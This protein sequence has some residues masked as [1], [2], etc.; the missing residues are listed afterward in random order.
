MSPLVLVLAALLAP[1]ARARISV[2]MTASSAGAS[3]VDVA[4][5]DVAVVQDGDRAA[6]RLADAQLKDA[7][8]AYHGATPTD[9]YLTSPTPWG[10]LYKKYGWSE[11]RR[12]LVPVSARVLDVSST[13]TVVARRE[14]LNTGPV[15]ATF[16]AGISETVETTYE[17]SWSTSS[18]LTVGQEITY[19][20]DVE[21]AEVGGSTSVSW[22]STYGKEVRDSK[23]SS[24]GSSSSVSVKL[25]PG[26]GVLAELT[27]TRGVMRV[28]VQYAASLDGSVACNY[29]ATHKGHHFW[30]YD[31]NAVLAAGRLPR[32]VE[33][34]EEIR[35]GFYSNARV[36]VRNMTNTRLLSAAPPLVTMMAASPGVAGA[37]VAMVADA[38]VDAAVDAPPAAAAGEVVATP[39]TRVL[40]EPNT[41]AASAVL[42]AEGRD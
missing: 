28:R 1:A 5:A 40:S 24:V 2:F 18:T 36:V 23:T 39:A 13:P 31:V 37:P 30:R 21:V 10:D 8:R 42:F 6:F 22:A 14:F 26:Q 15:D 33:S 12:T 29:A 3:A 25:A 38:G 16:D 9:A 27:A 20:V 35:I 34:T 19:S 11:V 32:R 41:S 4:G 7:V 17:S